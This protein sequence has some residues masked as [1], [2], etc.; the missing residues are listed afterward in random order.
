MRNK[1]YLALP[2]FYLILAFVPITLVQDWTQWHLPEGAKMRLG[3]GSIEAITHSPDGTKFAVA[4]S[5]GIWLHNAKTYQ[6]Y[7]LLTGHTK[8]VISVRLALMERPSQVVVMIELSAC[9]IRTRVNSYKHSKCMGNVLD[10]FRLAL[11][12][13]PSQVAVAQ[14]YTC[15]I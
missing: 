2:A 4:G 5:V 12:E 13:R 3:K 14:G 10:A 8:D 6:E 7:A 1:L 9:G 11:M 15:G